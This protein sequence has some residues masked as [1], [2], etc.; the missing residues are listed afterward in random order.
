[1]DTPM[2]ATFPKRGLG[3]PVINLRSSQLDIQ[4]ALDALLGDY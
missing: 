2:M 4:G 3:K 1:M